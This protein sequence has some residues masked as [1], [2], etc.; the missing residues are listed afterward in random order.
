MKV[1]YGLKYAMMTTDPDIFLPSK[2]LDWTA[3]AGS[4]MFGTDGSLPLHLHVDI[5]SKEDSSE[6]L[7]GQDCHDDTSLA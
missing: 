5:K 1:E 4:N 3:S 7:L 6:Y 2:R